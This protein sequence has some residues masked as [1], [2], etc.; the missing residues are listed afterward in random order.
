MAFE[1][2]SSK[3]AVARAL[4]QVAE[5]GGEFLNNK[6]DDDDTSAREKLIASARELVSAAE[7]PVESLL[8][9]IWALPTRTV[10]ARIAI[11]LKI[12]ETLLEHD[13]DDDGCSSSCPKSSDQL[14]AATGASP[15]LVRRIC[16]ACVSMGMLGE[17]GPDMYPVQA[18]LVEGLK[19]RQADSDASALIDV[20]GGTGQ[21]LQDFRDQVPQYAGRLVLQ[22]VPEV[23][24]AAAAKGVGDDGR[25]ELQEHDFFAAQPVRGARAYFMR[26]V[27]HD[28]PDEQCRKILGRLRDV[29]EP[30][31]SRIL[32]SDCVVSDQKAAWQ[33]ASLDFF[34]MAL[35]SS[36][37]RTESEWRAL[38]DS[39]DLVITGIYNKGYGN[40]G[41]IEVVRAVRG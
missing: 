33:H 14:A 25:I 20:G 5:H 37:E 13:D 32:I 31:Y 36:R 19:L 39:C 12:F 23:V 16:R 40:E 38:I 29:M 41:L 2:P 3:E 30:G 15:M 10:A 35:A 27:L 24:A 28:W 34:M 4:K 21:V 18:R 22:E 11:D 7:T 17:Q 6:D 1:N 8:W 9:H 26:S